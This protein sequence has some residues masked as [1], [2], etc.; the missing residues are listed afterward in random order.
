[1]LLIQRLYCVYMLSGDTRV[2]PRMPRDVINST[3]V[4]CFTY[5]EAISG[6]PEGGPGMRLIQ[7]LYCVLHSLRRY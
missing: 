1:M 2:P 4:L 7:H 5:F 6:N 3:F